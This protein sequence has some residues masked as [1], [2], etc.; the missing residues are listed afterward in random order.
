M[1]Q[2]SRTNHATE[3]TTEDLT[4]LFIEMQAKHRRRW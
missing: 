2:L 1:K 4:M 3:A